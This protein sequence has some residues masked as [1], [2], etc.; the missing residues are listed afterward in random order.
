MFVE[1]EILPLS[2]AKRR[3]VVK[4]DMIDGHASW[5]EL[6]LKTEDL[7]VVT[8]EELIAASRLPL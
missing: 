3:W 8:S 2:K 6:T 4:F 5:R 7:G 1:A